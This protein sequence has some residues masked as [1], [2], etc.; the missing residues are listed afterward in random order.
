MCHIMSQPEIE[1]CQIFL[2][3]TGQM[4]HMG[5]KPSVTTLNY[6]LYRACTCVRY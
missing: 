3:D 4:P 6:M 5:F 1:F 2:L